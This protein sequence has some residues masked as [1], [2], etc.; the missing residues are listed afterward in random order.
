MAGTG[1]TGG[2]SEERV[3]SIVA[4]TPLG[5]PGTPDGVATAVLWLA[6]ETASFV[7]GTVIAVNAGWRIG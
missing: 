4:E 5:R 3:A 1:F 2:R 7:T 6:S